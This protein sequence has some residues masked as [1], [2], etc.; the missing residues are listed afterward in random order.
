MSVSRRT[1]LQ[2][3]NI[4]HYPPNNSGTFFLTEVE[5]RSAKV[6]YF[7]IRQAYST[8]EVGYWESEASGRGV[9]AKRTTKECQADSKGGI[10]IKGKIS[11]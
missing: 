8:A 10:Y 9:R 3:N 2:I 7:S 5:Y 1:R 6:G 4:F 11:Q